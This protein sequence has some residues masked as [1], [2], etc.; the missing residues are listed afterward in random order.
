[1]AA[2]FYG[3]SALLG[4]IAGAILYSAL[5]GAASGGAWIGV[6]FF[7]V[8]AA[9]FFFMGRYHHKKYHKLGHTPLFLE[10][11]SV[12]LGEPLKG[13]I[14][15]SKA[16]FSRVKQV[17]LKNKLYQGGSGYERWKTL[18]SAQADCHEIC[19]AGATWLHFEMHVP[20]EGEASNQLGV[21]HYYWE[22]SM[23]YT[24][25]LS[26]VTRTWPLVIKSSVN[27]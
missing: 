10:A 23:Q 27:P 17:T 20:A 9:L 4:L 1:M 15:V 14:K 25:D 21:K 3:V 16:N 26:R 19:E 22:L 2:V 24:Q 12:R 11:E 6:F 13:K 7:F 18:Q 5:V 8:F